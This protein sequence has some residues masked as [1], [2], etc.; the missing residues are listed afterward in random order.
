MLAK[1][2]RRFFQKPYAVGAAGLALGYFKGYWGAN[3]RV[4]DP[5]L[6]RYFRQQQFRRL[7]GQPSLW[8]M[9]L[10]GIGRA[11]LSPDTKPRPVANYV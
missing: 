1:C 4:N 8:D 5:D 11:T 10:D 3:P 9:K 7:L 6:I 2:V